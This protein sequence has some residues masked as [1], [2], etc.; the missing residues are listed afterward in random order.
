MRKMRKDLSLLL[1]LCFI[2][3]PMASERNDKWAKANKE[4]KKVADL[5]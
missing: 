2:E 1:A 3:L 5:K 4:Q